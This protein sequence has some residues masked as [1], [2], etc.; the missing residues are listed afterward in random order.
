MR[1][2]TKNQSRRKKASR[3]TTGRDDMVSN[4]ARNDYYVANALELTPHPGK[5]LVARLSRP[6]MN[7]RFKYSVQESQISANYLTSTTSV[8]LV[9]ISQGTTDITRT[10]DRVHFKRFWFSAKLTGN[11]ASTFPTVTR[12]VVFVQGEPGVGAVNPYVASQVLQGSN[13]YLPLAAYSRDYGDGYQILYD[14]LFSV[15]P[16]STSSE[17]ELLHLDRKISVQTEFSAGATAPSIND[18]RILVVCDLTTNFPLL[19]YQS[20]LWYEDLDA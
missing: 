16:L 8:S 10:G 14:G 20:T 18:I 5:E 19:T 15:N 2:A 1:A 11:A 13:S 9:S 3:K 17:A 6:I 4:R 7:P 12:V